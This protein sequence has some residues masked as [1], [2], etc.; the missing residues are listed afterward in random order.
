LVVDRS[1][2]PDELEV[3]AWTDDDQVMAL[4]HR[5]R[6]HIGLQFHPESYL[7]REGMRLMARFLEQAGIPVRQAALSTGESR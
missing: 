7:C 3:I 5:T 1:S 2:L 4:R 6:P